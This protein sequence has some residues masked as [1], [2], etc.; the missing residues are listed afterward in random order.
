METHSPRA[1]PRLRVDEMAIL[2]RRTTPT[3]VRLELSPAQAAT[4]A[5][6]LILPAFEGWTKTAALVVRCAG[7]C[8]E[9]F[10]VALEIDGARATEATQATM[11][12]EAPG[13]TPAEGAPARRSFSFELAVPLR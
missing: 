5:H 1:T 12:D 4:A 11:A 3:G 7:L 6:P 8:E 10:S 9:A 13:A 2:L